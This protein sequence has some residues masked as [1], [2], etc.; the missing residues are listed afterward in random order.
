L[1][2]AVAHPVRVRILQELCK[3]VKCVADFEDFLEISQP[4]VSQHSPC[5]ERKE[6]SF[7]VDGR[8]KCSFSVDP[9]NRFFDISRGN[10]PNNYRPLMLSSNKRNLSRK[11][12]TDEV[13]IIIYSNDPE[14]VWNAFRFGNFAI[15]AGDELKV[16]LTGKRFEGESIKTESF[17]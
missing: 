11:G 9:I 13:G 5:L 4:N 14:T 16:S 10:K 8:L 6:L 1:L 3:G 7:Y 2:R 15:K 12:G 17:R